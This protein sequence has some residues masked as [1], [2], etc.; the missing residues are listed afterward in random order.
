MK[1]LY[2]PLLGLPYTPLVFS[3]YLFSF[4]FIP[5]TEGVTFLKLGIG[6]RPAGM[7][8]AFTAMGKDVHA[9]YWNPAGLGGFD[10]PVSAVSHAEW[11]QGMR[12]S[13][14]L[15]SVPLGQN[16]ALAFGIAGF[17]VTGI[18]RRT[19]PTENPE[20]RFDVY[21]LIG[22]T[23]YARKIGDA[24]LGVAMKLLY[25]RLDTDQA[26]SGA[27]D[28][29]AFL[30]LQQSPWSFGCVLQHLGFP[31]A[32]GGRAPAMPVVAKFGA[33][34]RLEEW[35]NASADFGYQII[36][37]RF[38]AHLGIEGLVEEVLVLRAGYAVGL[39]ELGA[40]AG[41]RVGTGFRIGG[42]QVDY[43]FTPYGDLGAVH[44]ISLVNPLGRSEEEDKKLTKKIT[45]QLI[46]VE[47][48]LGQ[49][50][51]QQ[52]QDMAAKDPVAAKQEWEKAKVSW[53]K[54]LA[55]SPGHPEAAE[56]LSL[57]AYQIRTIDRQLED[58]RLRDQATS[59]FRQR[60][61]QQA[62][63][64]LRE[65]KEPTLDDRRM[66]EEAVAALKA[67]KVRVRLERGQKLMQE[68]QYGEALVEFDVILKELAPD[69]PEAKQLREACQEKL[70]EPE[71]RAAITQQWK[72]FK[73]LQAP[74]SLSRAYFEAKKVLTD[75]M[76]QAK[77]VFPEEI[78]RARIALQDLELK[79]QKV[80]EE[81]IQRARAADQRFAGTQSAFDLA[82]T[83]TLW[84]QVMKIEETHQEAKDW[85]QAH[86]PV[87]QA[88]AKALD[89]KALKHYLVDE[90]EEA[91]KAWRAVLILAPD[92]KDAQFNLDKAM[93]KLKRP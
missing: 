52:A 61:W 60:A 41:L 46:R 56:G 38:V 20:G 57:A 47:T 34:Y 76:A 30:P 69:H 82:E 74:D 19:G 54:I 77:T 62:L 58:R 72:R 81:V 10:V 49:R 50:Y 67:E 26:V 22:T 91:V 2:L 59:V 55:L 1:R 25:E 9:L 5:L 40:L 14:A 29:G 90:L 70:K 21:D 63:D 78:E 83:V 42:T 66:Q 53:D 6:A 44:R 8:E 43:A 75:I 88:K 11:F 12:L 64:L 32:M 7:G 92:Y 13:S 17:Y 51:H 71:L 4:C 89:D 37:R 23:G 84:E 45:T 86:L 33:S 73:S 3:L 15:L 39:P 27:M 79:H 85:R 24:W 93:R 31:A 87:R 68:E 48:M 16:E 36:D 35:W 65:I 28:V 18:E 80:L